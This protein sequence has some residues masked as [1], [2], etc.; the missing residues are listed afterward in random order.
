M[1]DK[2]ILHSPPTSSEDMGADYS[3]P[4]RLE[5]TNVFDPQKLAIPKAAAEGG[6]R[7]RPPQ[8]AGR[9]APGPAKYED[10]QHGDPAMLKNHKNTKGNPGNATRRRRREEVGELGCLIL[11]N[12][13]VP[14]SFALVMRNPGFYEK[15]R[16]VSKSRFL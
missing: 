4:T 11:I 2:P 14:S 10:V 5:I 8:E 16:F 3:W 9:K 7:R 6:R 1:S 13:I 12:R 15:Y